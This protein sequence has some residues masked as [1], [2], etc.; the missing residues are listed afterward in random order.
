M[1]GTFTFTNNAEGNELEKFYGGDGDD[2]IWG[3]A[4][5][6]GPVLYKGNAGDD[7]IYGALNL[8]GPD[9]DS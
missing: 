2:T 9:D 1:M 4:N 5:P 8:T 6:T 7:K 3:G